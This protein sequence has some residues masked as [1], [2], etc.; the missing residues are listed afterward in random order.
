MRIKESFS[1]ELIFI[2]LTKGVD[3]NLRNK[4]GKCAIH[5]A[6]ENSNT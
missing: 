4:K 1:N 5:L 2:I 3:A 6:I